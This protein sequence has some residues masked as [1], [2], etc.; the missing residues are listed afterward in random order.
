MNI[1]PPRHWSKSRFS[2]NPKCDTLVNNMTEAF[3]SVILEYRGNPTYIMLE[4]I[5]LYLMNKW[6]TNREKAATI[7][8]STLSKINKKLQKEAELSKYWLVR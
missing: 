3:S 5:R 4:D 2:M 6:T 8:G 7:E 1:A